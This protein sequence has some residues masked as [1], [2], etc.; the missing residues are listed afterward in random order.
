M[1]SEDV[2]PEEKNEMHYSVEINCFNCGFGRWFH[3]I[4][5]GKQADEYLASEKCIKCGCN[6]INQKTKNE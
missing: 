3:K 6:I 5:I 1:K 4:P 2:F